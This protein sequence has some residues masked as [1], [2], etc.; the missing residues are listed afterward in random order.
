MGRLQNYLLEKDGFG[1]TLLRGRVLRGKCQQIV[2]LGERFCHV[3]QKRTDEDALYGHGKNAPLG[4]RFAPECTITLEDVQLQ[5]GLPVDGSTLTGSVQSAD[6]EAICY[7]LLSAI[8]NNIYGGRSE[9]SWLRDTFPKLG[10]DSTEVQRIRYAR[11]H[12]L[13]M[14][15]GYL[16][17]DLS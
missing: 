14:L 17:P 11:A 16:I 4:T 3:S 10:N 2:P 7:N 6:W 9:M 15:G 12:I 1:K 13:E 8:P 5:L